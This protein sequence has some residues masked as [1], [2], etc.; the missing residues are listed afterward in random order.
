MFEWIPNE[1]AK[2]PKDCDAK[3]KG[4]TPQGHGSQLPKQ[5]L[6]LCPNLPR[7]RKK[8]SAGRAETVPH[9][10]TQT[11]IAK[12]SKGCDAKLKGLTP[13]GYGSQLPKG[14]AV[15]KGTVRFSTALVCFLLVFCFACPVHAFA[16][17][18]AIDTSTTA[19]GY[20]TVTYDVPNNVKMKVGVTQDGQT[21]Y[22]TYIPGRDAAFALVDGDGTYTITLYRN[23]TGTKY[24]KVE[25]VTVDVALTDQMSPYLVSTEEITF[26]DH[27][28]VGRT[29]ASLC[30]ALTNDADKVV[31]IHNYM[32]AN[33]TYDN[34]FG[35]QIAS[36]AVKNYVPDTNETLQTRTG[37]CY[38][39]AALF[40]AMC[41]SQ[42]I[43]CKI[44]RGYLDGGY[45]AWNMVFVDGTWMAVDMTREISNRNNA[46]A[47]ISACVTS[48]TG[49]AAEN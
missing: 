38:D 5:D 49:Y 22:Y 40:A 7:L 36:G 4:L 19:D 48:L 15:M 20:F 23:T 46:A 32:A 25:S 2:Q 21:T 39:F 11:I 9:S 16:A 35:A 28:A 1:T 47:T 3:L 33:L 6:F 12:Q 37:V 44:V 43:P 30:S 10:S 31:A 27:D 42:G 41:R 34:A 45:H 17:G 18:S 14:D 8:E 26:S 13:Q 29:A 24:K